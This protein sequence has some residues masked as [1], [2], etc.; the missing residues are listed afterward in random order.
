MASKMETL[1]TIGYEAASI[2]DFLATL[3]AAGITKLVDI[4]ELPAS[5]R[6]G[7]SKNAL[8]EALYGIGIDYV[9]LKGLGDPKPGREAARAGEF[10]KFEKIFLEHMASSRA[11]ADLELA[12][13][14]AQQGGACLFCYERDHQHCHRK[15]VAE[16]MSSII[17]LHTRHLG[18]REGLASN[19][20]K[21]RA[22]KNARDG[23]GASPSR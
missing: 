15:Y 7:F 11:K 6:K 3:K 10:G 17:N 2:E 4:R 22:R 21:I 18:V 16:A 14:L 5:R 1:F 12:V 9:H 20:R 13:S 8:A 23:E 19:G